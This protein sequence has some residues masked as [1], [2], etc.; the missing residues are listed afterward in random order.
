MA[1]VAFLRGVNVGGHRRL[2]PAEIAHALSRFDVVN[3]GGAG[4]FVGRRPGS[5]AAFRA[6]IEKQVPFQVKVILCDGRDVLS[7]LAEYPL[8]QRPSREVIRFVSVR[9]RAGRLRAAIPLVIPDNG[10][11][12]VRVEAVTTRFVI[13][14]YRR[15]MRSIGYLGQLDQ[16]CG[17]PVT[18]RSWSTITAIARILTA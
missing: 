7:L 14:T 2:R 3:V 11:W 18:T 17:G 12:H 10:E 4:T 1:L 5:R 6:A 8:V 13:G 15:R 16:L 9:S